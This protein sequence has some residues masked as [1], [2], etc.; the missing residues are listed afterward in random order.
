MSDTPR[1]RL[2]RRLECRSRRLVGVDLGFGLMAAAA[3]ILLAPGIA[4]VAVVAVLVLVAC[5]VS[6]GIDRLRWP[7]RVRR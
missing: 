2:G 1:L 6:L 7:R 3:V 4:I 5:L